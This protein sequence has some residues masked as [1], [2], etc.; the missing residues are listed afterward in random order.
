MVPDN[1]AV[2]AMVCADVDDN[3][4]NC[5]DVRRDVCHDEV[6]DD[7]DDGNEA[8]HGD[9]DPN[10][11]VHNLPNTGLV[12]GCEQANVVLHFAKV[13]PTMCTMANADVDST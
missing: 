8:D 7:D 3:R 13:L 6:D 9:N 5:D 2:V 11:R 4:D 10:N 1:V 12:D